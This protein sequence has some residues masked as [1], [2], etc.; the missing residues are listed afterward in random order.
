M[1]TQ[2]YQ[3]CECCGQ[4]FPRSREFFKRDTKQAKNSYHKTCRSCEQQKLLSDNWKDGKL[5]CWHCG[6]WLDPTEFGDHPHYSYRG[7]KDKR[8]HKCKQA[9]NKKAREA[10]NDK[11]RLNK[12]IQ[13]RWLGAKKRAKDRGIPFTITKLEIHNLW[14][15]Q[16]GLCALSKI[17]MTY[18]LDSG[19]IYTNVSID[20][21]DPN[22]G[23]TLDNV[24]LVCMGVN[25]MKA[26]LD[27][28][29]LLFLC[30]SI[31]N[32]YKQR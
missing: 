1:F 22:K 27:M 31:L 29:T 12:V 25:Q 18:E 32:N 6:Q 26:D 30:K 20:Q 7:N 24:Q 23:Y 14:Q 9:Q 17:P 2:Q 13:S 19:R 3:K 16:N 28:P 21:I 10:Y 8:C 4:V 15:Q 5:K 11:V